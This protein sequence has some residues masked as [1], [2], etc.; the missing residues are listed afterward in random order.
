MRTPITGR[1]VCRFTIM[2][3]LVALTVMLVLGAVTA[4]FFHDGLNACRVASRRLE[5]NE[6]TLRL[7]HEWRD[8]VHANGAPLLCT[9]A[10]VAFGNGKFVAVAGNKI[11]FDYGGGRRHPY[12]LAPNCKASAAYTD[13]P[14]GKRVV[15]TVTWQRTVGHEEIVTNCVRLVACP[16]TDRQEV[17][18]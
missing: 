2:E 5:D 8:F 15:L 4:T 3:M 6:A 17:P 12:T 18:R 13:D 11:E 14:A 9:A 10:R 1:R 16:G 7:R